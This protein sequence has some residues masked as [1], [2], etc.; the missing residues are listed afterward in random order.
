[1]Y[2]LTDKFDVTRPNKMLHDFV[3]SK[4]TWRSTKLMYE[5]VHTVMYNTDNNEYLNS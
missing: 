1:M 2:V 3:E 4:N 5:Y